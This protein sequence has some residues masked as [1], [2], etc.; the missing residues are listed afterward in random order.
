MEHFSQSRP[1]EYD[2]ILMDVQMPVMNGYDATR[3]IRASGHPRAKSIPI[4]A[5]T[6]DAFAEDIQRARKAGMNAHM[7][8]PINLKALEEIVAE[9][10]RNGSIKK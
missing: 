10:K 1:E 9:L 8:K 5:M 2:L 3:A 4:V 7:A 6:A